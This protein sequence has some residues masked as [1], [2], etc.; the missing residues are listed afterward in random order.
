[1]FLLSKPTALHYFSVQ[2]KDVE[3]E[4]CMKINM[5]APAHAAP[6]D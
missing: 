6:S 2:T 3:L 5:Y 4:L 1:M